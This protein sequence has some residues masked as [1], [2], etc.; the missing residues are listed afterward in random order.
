LEPVADQAAA[1]DVLAGLRK[2]F[3]DA[4]HHCYAYRLLDVPTETV[5][6][7]SEDDGEPTGSAGAPIL[8][9]LQHAELLNVLCVVIRYFG[10]SKLGVGGLIRAYGDTAAE[11]LEVSDVVRQ[12]IRASITIRFPVEVNSGVMS[13]IHKFTVGVQSVSYEQ[14]PSVAISLPPSQVD[15]FIAAITE[16]T[17]ARARLEVLR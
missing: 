14:G 11:A 3:H 17:G 4:T 6:E 7:Q 10:G 2:R 16:A 1:L 13:T 15:G 8:H 9:T 12:E 5:L